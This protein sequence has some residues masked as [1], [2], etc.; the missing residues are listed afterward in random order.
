MSPEPRN[1]APAEAAPTLPAQPGSPATDDAAAVPGA[2]HAALALVAL[3]ACGGAVASGLLWHKLS[4]IQE[5]LA[6]QSADA[7]SLA[8]E[9][10]TTAREARD[11]AR[12][13]AARQSVAEARLGDV[14]LQRSQIEELMQSVSRSRD[15]N[16]VVDI[17]SAL[18]LALQ[19]TQLTGSLEPL[20]A[21]LKGADQRI[22]R[23]AQPRLAPL[24]RAIGHDIE[25]IKSANVTDTAGLLGRLDDLSRLVDD[26]PV[27]NTVGIGTAASRLAPP[28][29]A[30]AQPGAPA[31]DEAWWLVA[32]RRGWQQVRDEARGLVRVSRI[33]QPDA[34]LLAPEQTYFLR[35]NL[36]LKLQGARLGVLARQYEATRADLTGATALLNKY[37]DPASKRVQNAA[38][39]LQQTMAQ[40][41]AAELPRPDET[42][43]A[44]ATAAAAMPAR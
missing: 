43:N 42:L 1:D 41:R 10:R 13:I 9:A 27:V 12:D 34:A 11:L 31:A 18:R 37:F 44:L 7:N 20:L 16:L 15:E 24:A 5:Q 29:T 21:A 2:S 17:D 6:R 39:L 26:L 22:A 30:D 3:I 38:T 35:E 23:A 28:A 25:R 14:A 32:L 4:G 8:I 19:Q 36:K 40:A 33:D